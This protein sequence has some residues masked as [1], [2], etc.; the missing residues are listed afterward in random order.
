MR[1]DV[2]AEL[3]RQ[4]GELFDVL[5]ANGLLGEIPCDEVAV[6]AECED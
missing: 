5:L 6:L 1:C 2:V 4:I 3:V